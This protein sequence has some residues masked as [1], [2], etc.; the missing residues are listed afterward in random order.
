METSTDHHPDRWIAT[1]NE[2]DE[3]EEHDGHAGHDGHD[4]RDVLVWVADRSAAAERHLV[5]VAAVGRTPTGRLVVDLDRP[6]GTP[7]VPALNRLGTPTTGVAVTLTVPLLELLV[8]V[9][10]GAVLLGAAGIDD[11][12]VDD[13]GAVVLCD[14]PTNATNPTNS[15]NETNPISPTNAATPT[16]TAHPG[17]ATRTLVLAARSVW[18]RVDPADP[19]QAQVLGA[20][21]DALDGDGP[22][23]RAALDVVRAAAAPRPFRWTPVPSDL[24]FAEPPTPDGQDGLLDRLRDVVEHGVPLGAGRRLPLRRVLVGLVVTVGSVVAALTLLG[25]G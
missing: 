22:S 18:D 14:R 6:T 2:R 19:A 3:H 8:A 12:L 23:A 13:S 24:V 10:D 17:D 5:P 9:H 15:L 20:L 11:V 25:S 4:E 16:H 7:L 1:G 21:Q